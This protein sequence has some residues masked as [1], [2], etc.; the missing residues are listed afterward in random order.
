MAP[1]KL[2]YESSLSNLLLQAGIHMY[3]SIYTYIYI[4]ID[5]YRCKY[6]AY[7][8]ELCVFFK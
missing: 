8:T 2:N 4:H 7:Q 1:V 6:V 3:T 5:I